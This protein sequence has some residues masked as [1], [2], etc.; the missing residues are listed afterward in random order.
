MVNEYKLRFNNNVVNILKHRSVF[1]VSN[2]RGEMSSKENLK[3]RHVI[4]RKKRKTDDSHKVG[5]FTFFSLFFLFGGK[6]IIKVLPVMDF[7]H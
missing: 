6:W 1:F 4:T 7:C 5:C 3:P 2:R